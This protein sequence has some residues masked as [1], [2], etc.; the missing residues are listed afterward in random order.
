[1]SSMVGVGLPNSRIEQYQRAIEEGDL[2]L[3]IDVHRDR[4]KEVEALVMR[5]H[6]DAKL[7]GVDPRIPIFP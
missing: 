3:M 1:M 2:L 4:V 7:E 5:H 6:P